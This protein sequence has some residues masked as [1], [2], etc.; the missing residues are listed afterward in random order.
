M[1]I[2]VGIHVSKDLI[3]VSCF[4]KE[5]QFEEI[6]LFEQKDVSFLIQLPINKFMVFLVDF[7]R[8]CKSFGVYSIWVFLRHLHMVILMRMCLVSML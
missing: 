8:V 5:P 3:Q 6:L 7:G 1:L 4:V 2:V